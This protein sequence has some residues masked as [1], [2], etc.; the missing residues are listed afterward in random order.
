MRNL[1]LN[2]CLIL[3][4]KT[5]EVGRNWL[6]PVDILIETNKAV[7]FKK[8]H[9]FTF[10]VVEVGNTIKSMCFFQILVIAKMKNRVLDLGGILQSFTYYLIL[11]FCNSRFS[12][13][14]SFL[15]I[16]YSFKSMV[17]ET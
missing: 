16:G 15:V 14:N 7:F 2:F 3:C 13:L 17:R 8:I 9:Y 12:F 4:L 10:F 1:V 6:F 5:F 11:F